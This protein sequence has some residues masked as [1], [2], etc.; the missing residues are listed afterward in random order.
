LPFFLCLEG[1]REGRKAQRSMGQKKGGSDVILSIF[2]T[3]MGGGEKKKEGE[4]GGGLDVGKRK[5]GRGRDRPLGILEGKRMNGLLF[6]YSIRPRTEGGEE[7]VH[8]L[9]SRVVE[10]KERD[11]AGEI[12][13]L[14][15]PPVVG[16]GGG[17]GG[18]RRGSRPHSL[19]QK[20]KRKEGK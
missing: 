18:G 8:L 19:K 15:P 14:P 16:G 10:K 7:K 5:R 6:V 3:P 17:K 12:P 2:K 20:K 1:R 13:L 4:K 9:F 11:T